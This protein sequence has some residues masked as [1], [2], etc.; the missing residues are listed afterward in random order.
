[1]SA[2]TVSKRN[3]SCVGVSLCMPKRAP[4]RSLPLGPIAVTNFLYWS[5]IDKGKD[6]GSVR[7]GLYPILLFE[8]LNHIKKK[9]RV[10][11]WWKTYMDSVKNCMTKTAC[12]KAQAHAKSVKYRCERFTIARERAART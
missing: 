2:N 10:R 12:T 6:K 8:Y 4:R 1:M 11:R 7:S 9:G 3:K 5:N